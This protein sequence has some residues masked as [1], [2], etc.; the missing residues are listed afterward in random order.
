MSFITTNTAPSANAKVTVSF[1]GLLALRSGAGESLEIGVHRF[2][3]DHTFQVMLVVK[4]PN[5]PPRLIRLLKGPLTDDLEMSVVPNPAT[6]FRVFAYAGAPDPFD[7]SA[8]PPDD[9]ELSLDYRW[10]FNVRSLPNHRTVD[11]NY[12]G[13]PIAK[14]NSGVLYTSTLT[15]SSLQLKQVCGGVETN[16]HRIA[17]DLAVAIDLTGSSKFIIAWSELGQVQEPVVLPRPGD[18]AGTLYSVVLLNDPPISNPP[19]HDELLEYY[20]ILRN[21]DGSEIGDKCT[22]ETGP[23]HKTDEIPCLAILLDP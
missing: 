14:L 7:R 9:N 13:H 15:R 8:D 2:S 20:K 11:F 4:K 19:T 3:S 18:P 12:G 6:K 1:A 21:G 23:S 5:R 22:L 17:A 10:A 16:P